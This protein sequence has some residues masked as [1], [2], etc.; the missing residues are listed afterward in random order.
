M[1]NAIMYYY[2]L[3]PNNIRLINKYVKFNVDNTFYVLEKVERN[4]N[5]IDEIYNLSNYLLQI[6]VLCHQII[7]NI[8][9]QIIT[10]IND[11]PYVLMKVFVESDKLI[12]EEDL[13]NFLNIIIDSNQYTKIKRNNWLGL[14][15]NK[16]DYLEYQVSQ[17]G[18]KY[19]LIRD[20]FS[21]YIGL[22]ENA[23][24]FLKGLNQNVILTVSHLRIKKDYTMYDLYNPLEFII[25]TRVRDLAEYYKQRFYSNN[26]NYLNI[27]KNIY[28]NF[29]LDELKLFFSRMLFPT[30]YFD[31]YEDIVIDGI[32][33]NELIPIIT[34]VNEYEGI[35][36]K[37]YY[38]LFT[39]YRIEL[40][41]WLLIN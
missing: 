40:I 6:N 29:S 7:L 20:S 35:I 26:L 15:S 13:L 37:I 4:P 27:E 34:K 33:E 24:Q 12:N 5:E 16:I 1:K 19:M 9:N 36:K 11:E 2:N 41:E 28:N 30:I 25:D 18:K 21:Y 23:I 10:I 14:W 22:A 3:V 17:F 38:F 8:N 31:I 39:Y 32:N